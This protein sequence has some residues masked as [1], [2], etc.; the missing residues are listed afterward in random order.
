MPCTRAPSAPSAFF[1]GQF[2]HRR[3]ADIG[4]LR[5]AEED[6]RD[7][8]LEV[9]QRADLAVG[10]GRLKSRA[11]SAPVMSM[12]LNAG[13]PGPVSQAA[14]RTSRQEQQSQPSQDQAKTRDSHGVR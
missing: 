12:A 3:R 1:T 6:D 14:S 13:L 9:G 4:A 8:A 10:I 2:D 7:L 11:Y 5:V